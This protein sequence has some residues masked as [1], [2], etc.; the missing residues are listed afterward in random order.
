M[1]MRSAEM[2]AF[3]VVN[4]SQIQRTQSAVILGET[5]TGIV[6]S[7][8]GIKYCHHCSPRSMS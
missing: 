1:Y 6:F 7:G 3:L 5:L 2:D 4:I 8:W